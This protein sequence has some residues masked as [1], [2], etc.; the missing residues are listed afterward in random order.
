MATAAYMTEID[1]DFEGEAVLAP[2]DRNEW[3]ETHRESHPFDAA[4][5]FAYA[6]VTYERVFSA[7]R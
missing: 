7:A 3:R 2:L 5:R 6:F 4:R 1:A